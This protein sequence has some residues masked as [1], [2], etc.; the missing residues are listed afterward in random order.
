MM[1]SC[2]LTRV[3]VAAILGL[4]IAGRALAT[5][6]PVSPGEGGDVPAAPEPGLLLMAVLGLAL[7]GGYILWRRRQLNNSAT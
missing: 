6:P 2:S 1:K 5:P 4:T 7:G 3:W